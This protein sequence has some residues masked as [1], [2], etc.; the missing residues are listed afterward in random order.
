VYRVL[1]GELAPW[2]QE[3]QFKR[4]GSSGL[5]LVRALKAM[6][7][8]L[9]FQCDR[10]GWDPYAGSSFFVNLGLSPTPVANFDNSVRLNE[11]LTDD[12]LALAL[13][14][15]NAIVQ[16]LRPPP[17]SYFTMMAGQF[18]RYP[19]GAGMLQALRDQFQPRREPFQRNQDF[20]LR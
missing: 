8:V 11:L 1:R 3:R 15:H 10:R 13:D 19:S 16:R 17:E 2:L 4:Q 9:W 14:Y 12:E 7:Q 6:N 5:V 20:S 18:S